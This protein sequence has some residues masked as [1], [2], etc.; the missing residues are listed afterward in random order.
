[1]F[2]QYLTVVTARSVAM[3][4][5][6]ILDHHSDGLHTNI[7]VNSDGDFEPTVDPEEM[8][9]E[10]DRNVFGAE[11]AEDTVSFSDMCAALSLIVQF[12]CASPDISHVGGRIAALGVLLDPSNMPHN[13]RTLA[14]V[15]R[16][17]GVTRAAVSK[18]ILNFRDQAG[19]SL[20]VGKRSSIRAKLRQSQFK[21][22]ENGSHSSFRRRDKAD[23]A[24]A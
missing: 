14:D 13:R 9:D 19:V 24:A 7:S 11:D 5:D 20:T 1:M 12:A 3:R 23:K 16:E 15:S 22:I 4:S 21:A 10:I 17:C 2:S 8:Y 6:Q 18:W